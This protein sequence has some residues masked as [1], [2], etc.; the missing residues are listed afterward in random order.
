VAFSPLQLTTGD[1][2]ASKQYNFTENVKRPIMIERRNTDRTENLLKNNYSPI[3]TEKIYSDRQSN[4][5]IAREKLYA[6]KSKYPE[7]EEHS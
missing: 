2:Q 3:S 5:F 1:A 4:P 6:V 7:V